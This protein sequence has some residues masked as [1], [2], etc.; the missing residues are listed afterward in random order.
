MPS[1]EF[2]TVVDMLKAMNP[3]GG[4]DIG[5]IREVMEAAPPYPK[6]EDIRWEDVDADALIEFCRGCLG[7]YEIARG[8]DLHDEPLPESGPGKFLKP[9]LREPYWKGRERAVN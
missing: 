3:L 5:A 8:I 9:T 2:H 6:P 7:G 1:P 4:E